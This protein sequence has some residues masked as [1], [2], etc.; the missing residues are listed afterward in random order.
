MTWEEALSQIAN[1]R[2]YFVRLNEKWGSVVRLVELHQG[3]DCL[4]DVHNKMI[5]WNFSDVYKVISE[6]K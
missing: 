5:K 4:V 6:H 1:D 2:K 3:K